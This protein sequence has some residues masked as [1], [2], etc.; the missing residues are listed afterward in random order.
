MNETTSPQNVTSPHNDTAPTPT[1]P[2]VSEEYYPVKRIIRGK[3]TPHGPKY[4]VHWENYPASQATW[5]PWE[6]LSEST[7]DDLKENPVRMFGRKPSDP[8][9]QT[10]TNTMATD[11]VDHGSPDPLFY[12]MTEAERQLAYNADTESENDSDD[13]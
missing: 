6:N 1:Q 2:Q 5:E 4:L 13:E 7:Q 10:P 3:Y 8:Q 11:S 9:P 12:E